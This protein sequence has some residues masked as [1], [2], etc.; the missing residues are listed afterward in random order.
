[1]LGVTQAEMV[2]YERVWNLGRDLGAPGWL[3]QLNVQLLILAQ[4]MTLQFVGSS[5]ESD[6][7][8]DSVEPA[9]DPFSLSLCPSPAHALSLSK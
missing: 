4:V 9:W 5:L 3:S 2:K 7:V 1:M 8:P 6:S